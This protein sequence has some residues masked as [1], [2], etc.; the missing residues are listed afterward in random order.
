M[1]VTN[2]FSLFLFSGSVVFYGRAWMPPRQTHRIRPSTVTDHSRWKTAV[3]LAAAAVDSNAADDRRRDLQ[4]RLALEEERLVRLQKEAE[5]IQQSTN[6]ANTANTNVASVTSNTSNTSNSS[7]GVGSDASLS[8][9]KNRPMTS[10][11]KKRLEALLAKEDASS[12][13]SISSRTTSTNRNTDTSTTTTTTTTTTAVPR[14][15]ATVVPSTTTTNINTTTNTNTNINPFAED[16]TRPMTTIE[17]K[18]LEAQRF[19]DQ[20]MGTTSTSSSSPNTATT[21]TDAVKKTIPSNTEEIYAQAYKKAYEDAYQKSLQEFQS[22]MQLQEP[23]VINDIQKIQQEAAAAR[24][25]EAERLRKTLYETRAPPK[26]VFPTTYPRSAPIKTTTAGQEVKVQLKD[27]TGSVTQQIK[28]PTD[29][30]VAAAIP[31]TV[32]GAIYLRSSLENRPQVKK[33]KEMDRASVQIQTS[34]DKIESAAEKIEK[35]ADKMDLV[36][37]RWNSS[38]STYLDGL[39][40]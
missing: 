31:S 23:T 20:M 21:T 18:R 14:D 12:T 22:K 8:R 7:D 13:T 25:A 16:T 29:V 39:Q 28:F 11:E 40:K 17:R 36:Q 33:E 26:P 19:R 24:Q 6:T 2:E 38:A 10:V 34:A 27:S 32:A 37:K 4:A 9:R 1:K 35:S 30:F 15:A 5:L 3:P